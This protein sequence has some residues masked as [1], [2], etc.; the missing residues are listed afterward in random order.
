MAD[1][2]INAKSRRFIDE[3]GLRD[4]VRFLK[5]PGSATIERLGLRLESP[6]AMEEGV[7]HPATYLIDPDGRIRLADVRRDFHI[8]LDPALVVAALEELAAGR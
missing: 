4:R 6:E 7:A 1:R 3:T 5:D 8:W 2:Q